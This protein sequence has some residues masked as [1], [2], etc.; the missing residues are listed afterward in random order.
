LKS[1]DRVRVIDGAIAGVEGILTR[2]KNRYRVVLS[3]DLLRQALAVEVDISAVERIGPGK[4]ESPAA[5]R[6][7]SMKA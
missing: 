7:R 6:S 5:P 3:V 2:V 4:P 1:G